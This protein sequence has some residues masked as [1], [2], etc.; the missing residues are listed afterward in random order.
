MI[1]NSLALGTVPNDGNG[2][3][4]RTGGGYINTNFDEIYPSLKLK[5][6]NYTLTQNDDHIFINASTGS[7]DITLPVLTDDTDSKIYTISALDITNTARLLRG[8]TDTFSDG[9]TAI[10]FSKTSDVIRV[11]G[12]KTGAKW[13]ILSNVDTNIS[14]RITAIDGN[15]FLD[16]EYAGEEGNAYIELD[17]G[18][19]FI[20]ND[21][22]SDVAKITLDSEL[23][24]DDIYGNTTTKIHLRDNTYLN[25][26]EQLIFNTNGSD[27]VAFSLKA[28]DTFD[29]QVLSGRETF[30]NNWTVDFAVFGG[31][32]R[33]ETNGYNTVYGS[34]FNYA[35]AAP[36]FSAVGLSSGVGGNDSIFTGGQY[37]SSSGAT[38]HTAGHTYIRGGKAFGSG[39]STGNKTGGNVYVDGGIG[40]AIGGGTS[41]QGNVFLVKTRGKV[42]IGLDISSPATLLEIGE[43][44]TI[45]G[46]VT[47]GYSGAITLDSGY[48]GAF[49]VTRHNYIDVNNLSVGTSTVTDACIMR[50]DAAP[51]THKAIDAGTTKTT[52]GTVDAWRKD[53][54]NGTIYYSPMYLSKTT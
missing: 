5:T 1:K 36:Q 24:I 27:N 41:I 39:S 13:V 46:G 21:G 28:K 15:S 10:T 22:A 3:D 38:A 11:Q 47:D 30:M 51:G 42:G 40:A 20:I 26:G 44:E 23:Y 49:T 32:T 25:A 37:E 29:G 12:Y 14:K 9:T 16:F 54:A 35:I 4:L 8:G 7:V 33:S 48:N 17:T 53:N 45:T 19:E 52:P 31:I 50:F 6:G 43:T 34:L 18:N 2:T